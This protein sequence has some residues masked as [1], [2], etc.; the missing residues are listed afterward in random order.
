MGKKKL[1]NEEKIKKMEEIEKCN[2]NITP[3]YWME[4]Y[5]TISFMEYA[6]MNLRNIVERSPYQRAF[7]NDK[8]IT[9]GIVHNAINRELSLDQISLYLEIP[10]GKSPIDFKDFLKEPTKYQVQG[11]HL[12]IADGSQRTRMICGFLFNMLEV[13]LYIHGKELGECK[14]KEVDVYFKDLLS[15]NQ[16][17]FCNTQ[18][19]LAI[20]QGYGIK[21]YTKLFHIKNTSRIGLSDMEINNNLY[22][23]KPIFDAC[24]TL[25]ENE[26]VQ[27]LINV[28]TSKAYNMRKVERN[29]DYMKTSDHG[30]ALENISK[31]LLM[32]DG[33]DSNGSNKKAVNQFLQDYSIKYGSKELEVLLENFWNAVDIYEQLNPLFCGV[34]RKEI[35][36]VRSVLGAIARFEKYHQGLILKNL[37]EINSVID[38]IYDKLPTTQCRTTSADSVNC[39][40]QMYCGIFRYI[41]NIDDS[42]N[43]MCR[44]IEEVLN[45]TFGKSNI[46]L[47]DILEDYYKEK[48]KFPA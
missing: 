47:Y 8:K 18:I 25:L 2:E 31:I 15:K 14:D 30:K 34:G 11:Y 46:N 13:T 24:F 1:T 17:I 44:S 32:M 33:K 29:E 23:D 21:G 48:D 6:Q 4:G 35:N 37:D 40:I 38:V 42:E 36:R 19:T 27:K 10:E 22:G 9:S 41:C 45:T 7:N 16:D 26:R 5:V 43:F 12:T 20:H 28:N 3:F 39:E